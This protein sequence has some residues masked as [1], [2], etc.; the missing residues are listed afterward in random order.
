MEDFLRQ[1]KFLSKPVNLLE[2]QCERSWLSLIVLLPLFAVVQQLLLSTGKVLAHFLP[3]E[4]KKYG[5]F[6]E[7]FAFFIIYSTYVI[8]NTTI[9]FQDGSLFDH[10]RQWT[11]LFDLETFLRSEERIRIVELCQFSYYAV[12]M[13]RMFLSE[14]RKHRDFP[15]MLI[16]HVVTLGL[17]LFSYPDPFY[18]RTAITIML[19]HDVSDV[20]L[21]GSKMLVY[22]GQG[23]SDCTFKVFA[24]VFPLSRL[25]LYPYFCVFNYILHSPSVA[26]EFKGH[27][28]LHPGDE[29]Y[30]R[31]GCTLF[32]CT[33]LV[34]HLYWFAL[35]VKM[36]IPSFMVKHTEGDIR[37]PEQ[38]ARLQTESDAVKTKCE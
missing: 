36:S 14:R 23:L 5:K 35:I 12:S 2:F 4:R 24:V 22:C 13:V 15:V 30:R 34:L 18:H 7:S 25:V 31:P 38:Q 17:I 20:F 28:A 19:V 1:I 3:L 37:S 27:P 29:N 10:E 11:N 8:I 26:A 6:S 33:L 16:H 9:L 21:E 32:L